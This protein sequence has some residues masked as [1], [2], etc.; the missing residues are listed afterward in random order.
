MTSPMAARYGALYYAVTGAKNTNAVINCDFL[1]LWDIP[2]DETV[3]NPAGA[4]SA[5]VVNP[6]F[7][8]KGIT[9]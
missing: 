8:S 9:S 5:A 3:V 7:L 1:D 6:N 4:G 2:Q